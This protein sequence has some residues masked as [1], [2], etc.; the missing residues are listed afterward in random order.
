MTKKMKSCFLGNMMG[1]MMNNIIMIVLMAL[2]FFLPFVLVAQDQPIDQWLIAGPA[3]LSGMEKNLLPE[4]LE[5]LNFNYVNIPELAPIEGAQLP[6]G[7]RNTLTWKPIKSTNFNGQDT[8]VFFLATYLEP[9]RW[10]KTILTIHNTNLGV[11][12]YLDGT[13]IK[14]TVKKDSITAPL[15]LTNEKHLLILKI[16]LVKGETFNFKASLS[17][18]EALKDEK[19][20]IS[21]SPQQKLNPYHILNAIT[22]TGL[23]VSG[24]GK[25]VSVSLKQVEPNSE[26]SINWIEILD[27]TNGHCLFSSRY[28]GNINNFNWI[29]G[30]SLFSFTRSSESQTAVFQYN[31]ADNKVSLI[32]G[33]IENFS[34]YWWAADGS[35]F[36]YTTYSATHTDSYYKHIKDIRDKGED[37][38][39]RYS[40][41]IHFT[42][43]GATHCLTDEEQNFHEAIISPDGS[44]AILL[45]KEPDSLHRPFEKFC[46]YLLNVEK[47][48]ITPLLESYWL[49]NV[50]WSYDSSQLVFLGGPSSFDGIG[51]TLPKEQIPNDF[52]FQAY[53]YDISTQK[54]EP[55]SKSFD[56][57]IQETS[58]LSSKGDIYFIATD[59]A[60]VG[61]FRYSLKKKTYSRYQTA[62]DVISQ[63]DF[64][65]NRKICVYWGSSAT[66]PHK[67][68]YLDLSSGKARVLKDFNQDLFRYVTIGKEEPWNFKTNSGKTGK[69][70]TGSLYFPPDFDQRKKYPC[71]VYYYGGTS[72]VIREFGGRYPKNWYAANG[73]IVYVLHPSGAVG[74]G[75]E[76][77]SVHVNDWGKV[78]SEEVIAAVQELIKTHPYIDPSR[79][80]AMGASYGGFLT[81]YLAT[82]TE[83]FTAYIS[84]A[85]IAS[86]SS[87]WGAGDWA[88]AYSGI[89]T[90]D[91]FPWN[92]KDIYVGHS[93][94]F[95]A[96]RINRP[97]LLLHGAN[98]NNVPPGESYQMFTALKVQG[99]EVELVTYKE[100]KH[101]IL[102]YKQ[103]LHWMRTIIAWWDK[104]LKNQP[105]QWEEMFQ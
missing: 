10:M 47:M 104:H 51:N 76:F 25:R 35:Y 91:S 48:T 21:L 63:A 11:T 71:I 77:S 45:S 85:G 79:I 58:W 7:K 34:S 30:S 82:Q 26:K 37:G 81:Q 52:D 103:R 31:L 33:G 66:T 3:P 97:L 2:T 8:G 73:Y 92:R 60:D 94:L 27:T 44:R 75:Q 83:I 22:V 56:P 101:W 105:G 72:P 100:Q 88:C 86:L 13:S 32:K 28:F 49:Q 98:D 68:Y 70:I 23:Q 38:E 36:L 74:F 53:I 84:H 55:I 43:G 69:T 15:E 96:E 65:L 9:P 42:G 19:I 6:W 12:V 64:A 89:A 39:Y 1:N 80:G 5:M 18:H 41:Y 24:D 87:Y 16:L 90:A 78:T 57:S 59:K 17:P 50:A 29:G 67:L 99:K 93:P 95:L 46:F 40:L 54:A 62:V 102:S 20:K 4:H 14:A 61:L